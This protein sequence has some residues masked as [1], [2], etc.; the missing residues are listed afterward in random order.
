ML[1]IQDLDPEKKKLIVRYLRILTHSMAAQL[2]FTSNKSEALMNRCRNT[3]NNMWFGTDTQSFGF[4]FDY[5]KPIVIPFGSDSFQKIGYESIDVVKR[6]YV[7]IFPQLVTE[8]VIPDDPAKDVNFKERD[9]D[10]IRT[11]KDS[12]RTWLYFYLYNI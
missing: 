6:M 7:S 8:L 2:I 5:S 11:Q 10:L 3:L 12:V 9:I 1:F 4:H